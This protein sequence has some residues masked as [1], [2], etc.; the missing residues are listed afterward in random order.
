MDVGG[1]QNLNFVKWNPK[2]GLETT[3]KYRES[4]ATV[5][6]HEFGH[7]V[8]EAKSSD[9]HQYN[10]D[11]DRGSDKQYDT[12]DDRRIE[13]GTEANTARANGEFPNNYM[14]TNHDGKLIE[15][16]SPISNV[17]ISYLNTDD[18]E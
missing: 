11:T 14:R 6:E 10:L 15:T 3:E 13:T 16:P 2:A 5:L 7:G 1:P 9:L 8:R 17:K 12:K 4:P 18:D